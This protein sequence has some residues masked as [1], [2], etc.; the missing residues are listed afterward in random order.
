VGVFSFSTLLPFLAWLVLSSAA[1]VGAVDAFVDRDSCD[2]FVNTV[3]AA[4]GFV[5][6]FCAC[7]WP[8]VEEKTKEPGS[9]T[10][11]FVFI[12]SELYLM[13]RLSDSARAFVSWRSC[14]W[15]FFDVRA[16]SWS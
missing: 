9:P 2:A 1:G 16:C 12:Y 14:G 7:R 11:G 13:D 5:A 15:A 4:G 8:W 10:R 6:F 3:G